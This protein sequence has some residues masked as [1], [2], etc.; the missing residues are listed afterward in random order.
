M[1][2]G[3]VRQVQK[4]VGAADSNKRLQR[5]KFKM[6]L[7]GASGAGKSSV[8]HVLQYGVTAELALHQVTTIGVDFAPHTFTH[9]DTKY[10]YLFQFYDTAGQERFSSITQAYFR[11]THAVIGV[12]DLHAALNSSVDRLGIGKIVS[13]ERPMDA[14]EIA[15]AM[16]TRIFEKIFGKALLAARSM[17]QVTFQSFLQGP[18]IALLGNKIDLLCDGSVSGQN[19]EDFHLRN[20]LKRLTEEHGGRYFDT[21]AKNGHQ[22]TILDA[23]DWAMMEVVRI[24]ERDISDYGMPEHERTP[25]TWGVQ[26][27]GTVDLTQMQIVKEQLGKNDTLLV[28]HPSGASPRDPR[29]PRDQLRCKCLV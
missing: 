23:L 4:A 29:Y 21:S 24:A 27:N 22:Q 15:D 10:H 25:A 7:V 18:V 2:Y 28:N 5:T 8:K 26:K 12:I 13:D 17:D 20:S 19:V 14:Q 9:P 1:M 6:V 3:E 16:A 11:S